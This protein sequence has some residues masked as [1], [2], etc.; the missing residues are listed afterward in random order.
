[1]LYSV[2][3]YSEEP[4]SEHSEELNSDAVVTVYSDAIV[5]LYS[6]SSD[7]SSDPLYTL[8]ERI[9]ELLALYSEWVEAAGGGRTVAL[10]T[11]YG[12]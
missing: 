11:I 9:E 5:T 1:M 3:D 4:Y 7:S 8:V 10:P 6:S 2:F 12:V